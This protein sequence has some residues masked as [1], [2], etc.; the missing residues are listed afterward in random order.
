MINIKLS[1]IIVYPSNALHHER[2]TLKLIGR[3]AEFDPDKS[4][5]WL[6]T[7]LKG[8]KV[9]EDWTTG[10]PISLDNLLLRQYGEL[11]D[12]ECSNLLF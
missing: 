7:V 9:S 3:P 12:R 6:C 8:S 2:S 4:F 10:E 1:D 5:F 11:L